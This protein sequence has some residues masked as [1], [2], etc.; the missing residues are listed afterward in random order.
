MLM[1]FPIGIVSG[2]LGAIVG[3]ASLA[4]YPALIMFGLPP[5]TANV[6]NLTSQGLLCIGSIWSS[7]K[8]IQHHY[9]ETL[10][11]FCLLL[12]GAVIGTF[13]VL[14]ESGSSFAK[15]VPFFVLAATALI[16]LP[17]TRHHKTSNSR[18]QF[19]IDI[20]TIVTIFLLGIY[21]AYFGAGSGI[22]FLALMAIVSKENFQTYNSIRNVAIAG[23]AVVSAV[24]YSMKAP[25]DWPIVVPLGLGMLI[26][27]YLG[28]I[29]VRHT[30]PQYIK[31]FVI[32]CGLVLTIYLFV[33]AY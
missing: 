5:I 17:R 29:I 21:C 26:G 18:K 15:V 7:L 32:F 33:K 16:L 25:V 22:I 1:F 9:R 27:G 23:P 28:P 12:V 31:S 20:I 10:L 8:D 6:T 3:I 24:V 13:I 11:Y 4:S 19:W 2:I 30:K 14:H